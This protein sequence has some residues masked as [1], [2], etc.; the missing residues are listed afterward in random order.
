MNYDG[1]KR[2]MIFGYRSKLGI[3]FGTEYGLLLANLEGDDKHVFIE[4]VRCQRPVVLS[5]KQ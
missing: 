2:K 4:N 3:V 5:R 1:K